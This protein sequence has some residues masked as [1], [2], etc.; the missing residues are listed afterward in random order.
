MGH[1]QGAVQI[2]RDNSTAEGIVNGTIK[3]KR[4]KAMD[5]RF[6]WLKDCV[7][8][9]D[10]KVYWKPRVT[11]LGDYMTK[12][13]PTVHHCNVRKL[14]LVN[15]LACMSSQLQGCVDKWVARYARI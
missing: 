5:M 14:Y 13:H 9:G 1:P 11:N 6:H 15:L 10:I 4:S 7:K 12:Y 3:R 8:R 2:R